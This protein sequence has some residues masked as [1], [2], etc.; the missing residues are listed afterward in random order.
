MENLMVLVRNPPDME[1]AVSRARSS[2]VYMAAEPTLRG[3]KDAG[4]AVPRAPQ[5]PA[6]TLPL[7][8]A[9]LLNDASSDRSEPTTSRGRAIF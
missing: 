8:A 1:C 3:K 4:R 5:V 7:M 2:S 6:Q 9:A